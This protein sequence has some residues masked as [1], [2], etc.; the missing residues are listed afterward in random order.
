MPSCPL[1]GEVVAGLQP[2][3][4]PQSELAVFAEKSSDSERKH[5]GSEGLEQRPPGLPG[6]VRFER[7]DTWVATIGMH[8]GDATRLKNFHSPVGSF[9]PTVAN[10]VLVTQKEYRRK[11]G[12]GWASILGTRSTRPRSES[13]FI[14]TPMAL[15]RPGF[16]LT[17]K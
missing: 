11:Y 3:S 12:S 2:V 6:S 15:A 8:L 16:M 1:S 7:A 9:S 10:V 14:I 17:G 5:F 13:S 4:R